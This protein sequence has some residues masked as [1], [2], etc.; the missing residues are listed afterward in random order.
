MLAARSAGMCGGGVAA[1]AGGVGEA[2]WG[3]AVR[4]WR[5]DGYYCSLIDPKT[6]C[7]CPPGALPAAASARQQLACW[8]LWRSRTEGRQGGWGPQSVGCG[9]ILTLAVRQPGLA[10][11]VLVLGV[12][13][14]HDEC[15]G[16]MPVAC[17]LCVDTLRE[18][19]REVSAEQ[20]TGA[21][22]LPHAGEPWSSSPQAG[23]QTT[24][25]ARQPPASSTLQHA[26]STQGTSPPY[27]PQPTPYPT[28]PWSTPLGPIA[29]CSTS[30]PLLLGS[31]PVRCPTPTPTQPPRMQPAWG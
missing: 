19:V 15:T 25:V 6:D 21:R 7:R 9:G 24:I 31:S 11:L 28:Y 12:T 22:C 26:D 2:D 30:S 23:P 14:P 13:N 20:L 8:A 1:A 29:R 17:H 10:Q 3:W 18:D 16:I 5:A 27:P 4:G